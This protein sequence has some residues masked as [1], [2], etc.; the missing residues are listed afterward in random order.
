MTHDIAKIDNYSVYRQLGNNLAYL[1]LQDE[2]ALRSHTLAKEATDKGLLS[3][4]MPYKVPSKSP[5]SHFY[6]ISALILTAHKKVK[7]LI[8]LKA[9]RKKCI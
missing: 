5:L 8:T 4:V 7:D 2:F 6:S 9:P 1:F 3:D